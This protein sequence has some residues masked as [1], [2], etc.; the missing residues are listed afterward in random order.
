[1]T[2][3]KKA[4]ENESS[5]PI[6][7][8]PQNVGYVKLFRDIINWEWYSYLTVRILF[9]HCLLKA[10]YIVKTWQGE[11]IQPGSFVTS[12]KHL[13]EETGL[14]QRQCRTAIKHLKSTGELTIRT[15][16]RYSI[17]TVN[18]WDKWQSERQTERQTSDKQTTT[19]KE[20]KESKNIYILLHKIYKE[21]FSNLN[22]EWIS[23]IEKW[24]DYKRAKKQ[25]YKT[26]Q[27]LIAFIEKLLKLSSNNLNTATQIIDESMANNW[28]GIFELKRT[29]KQQTNREEQTE[30]VYNPY[31]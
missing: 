11:I 13:S 27:S 16:S 17:I 31:V 6:D 20:R 21:K 25:T 19:T 18:N 10:N 5:K 29:S 26:E 4:L 30:Y 9:L 8:I 7:I 14:S 23:L 24:L 22:Q 2:E 1:M 28:S 3:N 15:T 12:L